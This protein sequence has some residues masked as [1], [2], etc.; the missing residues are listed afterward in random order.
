MM[1]ARHIKLALTDHEAADLY[2]SLRHYAMVRP[3][4]A[5]RANSLANL[6][7]EATTRAAVDRARGAARRRDARFQARFGHLRGDAR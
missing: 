1:S 3:D 2:A 5:A 6:V 4:Y 7:I